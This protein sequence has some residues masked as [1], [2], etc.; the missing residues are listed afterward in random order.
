MKHIFLIVLFIFPFSI[1]TM[2][3]QVY[4]IPQSIAAHKQEVTSLCTT[5]Y[6][7]L[8]QFRRSS[9]K[10]T[11][12]ERLVSVVDQMHVLK[13]ANPPV[14]E[15]EVGFFIYETKPTNFTEI[16]NENKDHM[17]A[18][19]FFERLNQYYQ[20]ITSKQLTSPN[21]QQIN[22]YLKKVDTDAIVLR[23]S[24]RN[25]IIPQETINEVIIPTS[26]SIAVVEFNTFIED[27]KDMLSDSHG[28]IKFIFKL[29]YH[30]ELKSKT[31]RSSAS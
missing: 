25:I 23:N 20:N 12:T 26:S 3:H 1:K 10:I 28:E 18:A 2:D 11:C 29:I 13:S 14:T 7:M 27:I 22:N 19:V 5:T 21:T 16:F 4:N 31:I 17:L 15:K 9:L 24:K 30:E 6:A 8:K